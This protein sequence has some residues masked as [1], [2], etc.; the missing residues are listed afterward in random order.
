M[1]YV[2]QHSAA[3]VHAQLWGPWELSEGDGTILGLKLMA[4]ELIVFL[5]LKLTCD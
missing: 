4:V 2:S 5:S 3:T 1:T